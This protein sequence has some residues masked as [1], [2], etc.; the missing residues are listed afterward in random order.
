MSDPAVPRSSVERAEF[1]GLVASFFTLSRCGFRRTTPELLHRALRS[2]RGGRIHRNWAALRRP[3]PHD[4]RQ[5]GRPRDA[6][7]T[8]D[9]RTGSLSRLNSSPAGP[10]VRARA[11]GISSSGRHRSGRGRARGP[12]GKSRR[13]QRRVAAG[14]R[15]RAG[16]RGEGV[17]SQRQSAR[18]A[19][20]ARRARVVPVVGAVQH[21]HRDR[22]AP[23]RRCT[24]R[25]PA[26]RCVAFLQR[27]RSPRTSWSTCR[28]PASP[29]VQLNDGPLVHE[30]FPAARARAER[31]LPG[32]GEL[33]VVGLIHAVRTRGL[34][35]P[36]CVESNTP[37]FRNLPVAEAARRAAD[38]AARC[39]L[40]ARPASW[41][42]DGRLTRT[43][44]R[45]QPRHRRSPA[46]L[47]E[48][49]APRRRSR[50]RLQHLG[51]HRRR[52]GCPPGRR[53]R[54]LAPGV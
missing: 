52:T 25:G 43:G 30:E 28:R 4:H 37:E 53:G 32:E 44:H 50:P 34:T 15:G 51:M 40:P 3:A 19:G 2:R 27:W 21:R 14:H 9:Q 39:A 24:E 18:T 29:G 10:S 46:P 5:H 47:R 38:T 23:S 36:Y 22:P 54:L 6:G 17:A 41:P 35:G 7:G 42:P 48:L 20:A 33:D 26:D 11:G 8:P 1:P 49:R 12:P 45:R 13:I 16:Q 31:Q